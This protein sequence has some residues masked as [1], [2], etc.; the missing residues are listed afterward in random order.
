MDAADVADVAVD[1]QDADV[2][3][4]DPAFIRA[5]FDGPREWSSSMVVEM[6][7]K[8]RLGTYCPVTARGGKF[9]PESEKLCESVSGG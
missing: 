6:V 3:P 1:V 2:D 9:S 8:V 5:R 7:E 4:F